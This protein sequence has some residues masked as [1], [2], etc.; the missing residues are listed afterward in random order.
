VWF[1]SSLTRASLSTDQKLKT[2]ARK[3][4]NK[5]PRKLYGMVGG[6][7]VQTKQTTKQHGYLT[8]STNSG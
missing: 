5:K 8:E 2:W 1:A 4:T 7:D 6:P 3:M